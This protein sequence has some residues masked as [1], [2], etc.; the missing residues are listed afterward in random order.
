M[1]TTLLIERPKPGVLAVTLNRPE[2]RNAFNE[3]VIQDLDEAFG[4]EALAKDV[5]CCRQRKRTRFFCRR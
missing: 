4:K 5:G 3:N 2:V 1:S